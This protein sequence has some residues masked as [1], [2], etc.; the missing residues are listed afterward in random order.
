MSDKI[1]TLPP[2]PK[3]K[4]TSRIVKGSKEKETISRSTEKTK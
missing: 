4:T 1:K 3:P 2:E